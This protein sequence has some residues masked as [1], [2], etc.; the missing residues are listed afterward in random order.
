MSEKLVLNVSN[1]RAVIVPDSH[2]PWADMVSLRYIYDF[3]EWFKPNV[4]VHAGDLDD[5]YNYGRYPKSIN[6]MTPR[7]ETQKA[8]KLSLEMWEEINHRVPKAKKFQL[9]GN[10]TE[11]IRKKALSKSPELED[12]VEEYFKKILDFPS[13]RTMQDE[14]SELVINDVLFIHGYLGNLGDHAKTNRQSV[15]VG[16]S[17]RGGCV[18]FNFGGETIFELNCGH[19]ADESKLPF[20]YTQ[21]ITT[22]WTKGFGVIETLKGGVISPRFVPL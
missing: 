21:Q 9:I 22:F 14:R 12:A 15:V 11:R 5:Q 7:E 18:P 2:F 19:I 16:H 6:L 8:R 17:H 20:A 4:V 10:H 1:L 3:I 13:V